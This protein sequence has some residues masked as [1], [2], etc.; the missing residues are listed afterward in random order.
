M[1]WPLPGVRVRVANDGGRF[2]AAATGVL[3]TRGRNVF[4]GYWSRPDEQAFTEDGW[5]VTGD[6][7]E[8]DGQGCI[9]ILGR[10]P[11]WSSP[12]A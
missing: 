7:A 9:R 1:G 10:R 12:A 3:E 2:E 4:A 6:V 11:T 8:I 5:F